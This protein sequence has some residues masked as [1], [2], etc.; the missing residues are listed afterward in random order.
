MILAAKF[1]LGSVPRTLQPGG[2]WHATPSLPP[3]LPPLCLGSSRAPP[4]QT[5]LAH[6]SKVWTALGMTLGTQ[7]GKC[8]LCILKDRGSHSPREAHGALPTITSGLQDLGNLQTTIFHAVDVN[9][10]LASQLKASQA[11]DRR[12]AGFTILGAASLVETQKARI[13]ISRAQQKS[14][15]SDERGPLM[16][17]QGTAWKTSQGR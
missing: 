4:P 16:D 15:E 11:P 13:L 7:E 2:R 1:T 3:G 12:V 14:R 10:A 17:D 9:K 5:P 6:V 8:S